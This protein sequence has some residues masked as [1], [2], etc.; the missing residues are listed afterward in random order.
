MS[1]RGVFSYSSPIEA[2]AHAYLLWVMRLGTCAGSTPVCR[3]LKLVA[4][5]DG[6]QNVRHVNVPDQLRVRP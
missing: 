2:K 5:N 1:Y 3:I 4:G 6:L